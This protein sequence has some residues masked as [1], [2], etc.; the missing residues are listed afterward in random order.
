MKNLLT[1]KISVLFLGMILILSQPIYAT[2][3]DKKLSTVKEDA[4]FP[5]LDDTTTF[6]IYDEDD[7]LIYKVTLSQIDQPDEKLVKYLNKSDFLVE[8]RHEKIYRLNKSEKK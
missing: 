7:S 4:G 8:Y 5:I 3:G 2:D 6:K 1:T